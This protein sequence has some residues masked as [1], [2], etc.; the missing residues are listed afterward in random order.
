MERND[1]DNEGVRKSVLKDVEGC[2]FVKGIPCFVCEALE[3]RNIV[4]EVLLFHLEFPELSLR[5]GPDG[6]ICVRVCES[7]LNNPP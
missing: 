6:S 3:F 4:V 5:S 2:F 7:S 1:I